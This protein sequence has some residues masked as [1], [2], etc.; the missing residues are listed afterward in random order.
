M[1]CDVQFDPE[2]FV[3]ALVS[4][5]ILERSESGLKVHDW[6]EYQGPMLEARERKR[7]YRSRLGDGTG[8]GQ[9]RDRDG[10]GRPP[11]T[12]NHLP[13]TTNARGRERDRS[14]AGAGAV[15]RTYRE[16]EPPA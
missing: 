5:A 4:C 14:P 11:P 13:P 6:L 2:T 7:T 16:W 12:T 3:Q 15:A 1:A 8:T 9:G 10:T